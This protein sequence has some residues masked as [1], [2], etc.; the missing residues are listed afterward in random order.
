MFYSCLTH[1]LV[2]GPDRVSVRS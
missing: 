2:L 1:S